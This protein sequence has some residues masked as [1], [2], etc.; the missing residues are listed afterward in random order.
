M[1]SKQG[2]NYV[3]VMIA[4]FSKWAIVAPIPDKESKNMVVIFMERVIC[5]V[6]A[7]VEALTDQG[8]GFRGTFQDMLDR[9]L[10]DHRRTS[11][12][13]PQANAWRSK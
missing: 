4:H 1:K 13:H 9:Y 8:T 10:I 2:H 5:T 11:C 3:M 6:G 12:N 7:P